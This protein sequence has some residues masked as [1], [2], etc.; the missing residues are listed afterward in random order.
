MLDERNGTNDMQTAQPL[1]IRAYESLKQMILE[2]QFTAGEIYSETKTSKE[3][4]LSRTPMRDAI[5]RLSQEGYIDVIPSKGF[6]LHEMTRQ[7]LEDTYQV[8]CALEGYCA[9]HLAGLADDPETHRVFHTLESLLRDMD[10]IAS[11]TGDVEEFSVYDTE[12]HQRLVYSLNNEAISA[13][14]DAYHYRMRSQTVAS[15][16][17]EGRLKNT[18]AEHRAMLESMKAGDITN[19]YM[20]TLN[21]IGQAKQLIELD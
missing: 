15:L 3:L 8:R 4:G 20:N 7:D 6:M 21:H 14:F 16:K 5:Q 13:T 18:V 10:A 2:G 1:Q 19:S 12:F 9:V 11:T 17:T